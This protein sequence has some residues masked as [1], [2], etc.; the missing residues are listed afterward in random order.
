MQLELAAV[1]Y[2]ASFRHCSERLQHSYSRSC[3]NGVLSSLLVLHSE[4]SRQY[5]L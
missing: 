1:N 2:V 5:R 4:A 3:A